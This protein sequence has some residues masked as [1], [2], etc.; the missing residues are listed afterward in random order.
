MGDSGI[1]AVAWCVVI[2]AV[3]YLW[4]R[5]LYERLPARPAG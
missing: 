1:I 2:S 5:R 4:S 3:G